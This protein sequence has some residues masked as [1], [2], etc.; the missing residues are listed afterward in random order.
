MTGNIEK[1]I[2]SLGRCQ[3]RLLE[4]FSK[5]VV[6]QREVLEE[7]LITVFAG[8][9]NLLMV[10][11]GVSGLGLL[12]GIM[13]FLRLRNLPVHKSMREISEL[14]Y[15]TCKTYLVTQGKFLMFLWLFIAVVI[16]LYFGALSPVPN[17]PVSTTLPIILLFSLIGIAGSYGVAWFGIRVNTFANSRTAFAGLRG[18]PYPIYQ[19]PLE[20][21]MSWIVGWKKGDFNGSAALREQKIN[22]VSRRLV[23]LEV[24]DRGIA[25]TGHQIVAGG[26][27]CGLVTSGTQTPFLKKAIAMAYVPV[28][29]AADASAAVARAKELIAKRRATVS[30]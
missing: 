27:P 8:G 23:G 25:R 6:G 2:E 15:E 13:M 11:L 21:G 20:A 16:V 28:E 30:A 5:V 7:L 3:R 9:H 12:F 1:Q 26:Q 18:K 24:L 10:G 14:I 22:G 17:K 29:Y 4:E 19:I